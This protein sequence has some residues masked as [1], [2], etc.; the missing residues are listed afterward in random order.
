M[1]LNAKEVLGERPRKFAAVKSKLMIRLKIPEQVREW[2]TM[3]ICPY[4]GLG[5]E[6]ESCRP[7]DI[8]K[9]VHARL[10]HEWINCQADLVIRDTYAYT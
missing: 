7:Q 9:L 8:L 3:V 10:Q 1:L 2:K 4:A 5:S 6:Y